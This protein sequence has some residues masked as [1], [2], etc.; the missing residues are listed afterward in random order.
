VVKERSCTLHVDRLT[1]EVPYG[2]CLSRVYVPVFFGPWFDRIDVF[3]KLPSWRPRTPV[4]WREHNSGREH[5]NEDRVSPA[6]RMMSADPSVPV[7]GFKTW[8]RYLLY[9]VVDM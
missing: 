4:R 7:W 6:C 2:E 8:S 3:P 5:K 1:A 9:N